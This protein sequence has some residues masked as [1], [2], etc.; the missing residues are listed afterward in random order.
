MN[1]IRILIAAALCLACAAA[2]AQDIRRLKDPA[3]VRL[4]PYSP[5]V[6]AGGF[7][8]LSGVVPVRSDTGQFVTGALEPQAHQ[9]FANLKAALALAGATLDDVV[10]VTVFLKSAGDFAAMNRVYAEYFNDKLPA[11]TT[12]PGMDWGNDMRIEIEAIAVDRRG[13]K[14]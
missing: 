1:P 8:F 11:R 9:A 10:K 12:V 3:A 13:V 7:V 6:A 5:A 14:P 2:G 4:A